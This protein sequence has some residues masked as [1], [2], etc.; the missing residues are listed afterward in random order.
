MKALKGKKILLAIFWKTVTD[1]INRALILFDK[2]NN[3]LPL[4][5]ITQSKR[6]MDLTETGYTSTDMASNLGEKNNT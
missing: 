5:R 6:P 2:I 4:F 3:A 1:C